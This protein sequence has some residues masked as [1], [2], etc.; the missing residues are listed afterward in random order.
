MNRQEALIIG[1]RFK[2]PE[3]E[4]TRKHTETLIEMIYDDFEKREKELLKE[5]KRLEEVFFFRRDV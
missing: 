5:I 4:D 3:S 2:K 1:L